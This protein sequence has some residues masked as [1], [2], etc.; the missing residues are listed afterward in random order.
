MYACNTTEPKKVILSISAFSVT[1][2]DCIHK[3]V[4]ITASA[5]IIIVLVTEYRTLYNIKGLI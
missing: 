5:Q 4:K 2:S 1:L 3:V